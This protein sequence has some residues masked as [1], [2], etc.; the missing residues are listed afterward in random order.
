MTKWKR[1][2]RFSIQVATGVSKTLVFR[3]NRLEFC[4][5]VPS[6][7]EVN[8]SVQNDASC[9]WRTNSLSQVEVVVELVVGKFLGWIYSHAIRVKHPL[10]RRALSQMT[11]QEVLNCK[12]KQVQIVPGVR[13]A[14]LGYNVY[15]AEW[16]G[17]KIFMELDKGYL[18]MGVARWIR[19]I[20]SSLQSAS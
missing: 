1:Q 18:Q 13:D 14:H 5:G 12:D 19:G 3:S 17:K 7:R 2:G 16:V 20:I 15:L 11:H 10:T 4:I 9:Y 8:G 6:Q